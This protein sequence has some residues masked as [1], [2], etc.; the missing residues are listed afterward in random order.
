MAKRKLGQHFLFDK[1]ILKK[2][3]DAMDL[4]KKDEVLEI[5]AGRGTL[6]DILLT[7]C[8]KVYAVEI[9]R[10]LVNFLKER[11]K[12]FRNIEIL[13]IDILRLEIEDLPVKVAIGNIPYYITTPIIFKLLD[14][15]NIERFGL[16]MQK[17]VAERI[18][19]KEG[20]KNFGI[21]TIAVN[22]QAEPEIKF[23]VKKS[24]FSPP[25][26]VDSAFVHF[27]KKQIDKVLIERTIEIANIAFSARRK[28]LY[29]N[30]KKAYG[31]FAEEVFDKFKI[32]RKIRPEDLALELYIEISK[33]VIE[34][35]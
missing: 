19:S 6:T 25:P 28:T 26:K 20:S 1:N 11:Y 35:L 22:V 29:N 7:R 13:D 33:F 23:I 5:G 34:K 4:T 15:E 16:L 17:E 18:V 31:D 2:I 24:C 21:L 3:V 10:W 27:K 14:S 12:E 32:D 30:L 8:K 9:D